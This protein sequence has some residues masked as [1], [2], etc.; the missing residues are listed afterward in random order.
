MPV[1]YIY[2]W[3]IFELISQFSTTIPWTPYLTSWNKLGNY[4]NPRD[5]K[6]HHNVAMH[7][8][9]TCMQKPVEGGWVGIVNSVV[10]F[11]ELS[12]LCSIHECVFVYLKR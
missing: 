9:Y 1:L 12:H 11:R 5:R 2:I 7:D 3:S 10:L 4:T 8:Y 6:Q